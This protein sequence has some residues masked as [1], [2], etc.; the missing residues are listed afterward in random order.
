MATWVLHHALKINF[1]YDENNNLCISYAHDNEHI[2]RTG[3]FPDK[4]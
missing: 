3:L 1:Y 2:N 4:G